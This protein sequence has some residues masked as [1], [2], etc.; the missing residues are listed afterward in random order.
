M[1]LTIQ[2]SLLG[3]GLVLALLG[4]YLLVG[5]PFQVKASVS[6]GSEYMSTSTA[7]SSVYGANTAQTQF[8]KKG[9]GTFGSIIITG[10]N[11]ATINIYDATTTDVNKRTG[12]TASS[13]ILIASIPASAVAGTYTFDARYFWGLT[14]AADST[15]IATATITYR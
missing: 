7:P 4:L 1:K 6:E 14:Y 12:N 8:L 2:K 9:P 5:N 10:A 3:I 15:A 11:T 13:T